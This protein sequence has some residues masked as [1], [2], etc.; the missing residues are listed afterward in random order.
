MAAFGRWDGSQASFRQTRGV[1]VKTSRS[2]RRRRGLIGGAVTGGDVE[3]SPGGGV[4][5]RSRRCG[6]PPPGWCR[7]APSCRKPERGRAANSRTPGRLD[8]AAG[9]WHSVKRFHRSSASKLMYTTEIILLYAPD[10][11]YILILI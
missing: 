8:G 11:H 4:T 6:S 2:W 3:L 10:H 1:P 5:L 7:R 9:Q